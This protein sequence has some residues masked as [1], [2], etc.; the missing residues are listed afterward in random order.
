MRKETVPNNKVVLW[1]E[2]NAKVHEGEEKTSSV[3]AYT[4]TATAVNTTTHPSI[5]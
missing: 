2:I 4:I 3:T 1:E 5:A